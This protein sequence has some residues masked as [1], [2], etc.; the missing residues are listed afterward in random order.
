MQH[1]FVDIL[2]ALEEFYS[3]AEF[4]VL[5]EQCR[6]WSKSR[7]FEGKRLL[8][9]TPVYRNTFAKYAALL[10]GGAE[11]YVPQPDVMPHDPDVL[12]KLPEYGISVIDPV[13]AAVPFDVVLDCAGNFS[14]IPSRRGY[15]ELTKS[16]GEHYRHSSLPVYMVDDSLIKRVETCLGTGE[17]FFRAMCQLGHTD[18]HK[19]ALL[20]IGYG[21]VGQGI[22]MNALEQGILVVVSDIAP[23]A[24]DL[25]PGILFVSANDRAAFNGILRNAYCAV[26]ATG[27][28]HAMKRIADPSVVAGSSVLLANMGVD[29]EWGP[30]IPSDRVLN[31]RKPLN[32]I[33]DD[34]T[35]MCFIDPPL[36][37]HN[38]GALELLLNDHPPGMFPPSS[39]L[40]EDYMNIIR[41]AGL[42]SGDLLSRL[43]AHGKQSA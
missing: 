11:L 37:L 33:L 4:P 31:G 15:V 25:P 9:A 30:D 41:E 10:A 3:P 28:E 22:V 36:A 43:A 29:D 34:P 1:F 21:K 2:D 16:G 26:T 6:E 17:S 20:V 14:H 18:W 23:K 39:V 24:N 35:S 38:A 40:E 13:A 27:V 7:P 19:G 5:L 32:F 12:A 8:D 42:I